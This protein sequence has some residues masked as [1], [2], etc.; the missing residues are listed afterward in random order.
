M[1]GLVRTA[2]PRQW[3]KNAL[4]FAAP[5]AARSLGSTSTLVHVAVVAGAFCMLASGTY[6]LND[7]ADAGVDRIHPLK[8]H[9]PVASGIV[10][11]R[12]ARVVGVMLS[13]GA[14]GLAATVNVTSVA[15][16]GIYTALTIGYST[17]LKRFPVIDIVAVSGGFLLRAIAG[18]VAAHVPVS[19]PFLLLASFGALFLVVGKREGERLALGDRAV[20]HRASL[21]AYGSAFTAQILSLSLTATVLSYASWAFTTGAGESG[22]PWIALSV[23]P[24]VVAMLRATQLVLTGA[25]AEPEEMFLRDRMILAAGATTVAL[26][27]IAFY[28]V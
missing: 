21:A 20:A 6:L 22:V 16:L 4:V 27:T 17:W 12:L 11:V 5:F 14:L 18:A 23:V 19:G 3:S 24:F 28:I 10:S 2:R 25:G 13:A 26:L 9:R 7:A 8:R 15:V 1:R